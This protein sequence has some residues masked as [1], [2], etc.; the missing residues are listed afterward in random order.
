MLP[1]AQRLMRGHNVRHLPLVD[2]GRL[3][4]LVTWGDIRKASASDSTTLSPW[5]LSTLLDELPVKRFMIASPLTVTSLTPIARAAQIMMDQ[6]IGGLPVME[7]GK[8]VG[9]IAESDI[10]RIVALGEAARTRS[11]AAA[12]PT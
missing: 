11:A 12:T 6:I 2:G 1:C 4:G 3:V 10:M 5:E 8:L 7:G 9:I